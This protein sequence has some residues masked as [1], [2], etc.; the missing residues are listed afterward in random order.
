M[1]TMQA[2][3][4]EKQMH[5]L[6]TPVMATQPMSLFHNTQPPVLGYYANQ[7]P[8]PQV[9]TMPQQP[10]Q[11]IISIPQQTH[12]YF[13]GQQPSAEPYP[14]Q[15]PIPVMERPKTVTRL[16]QLDE[17]PEY[18]DCPYC[19]KRTLTKVAHESSDTTK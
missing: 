14:T 1:S 17:I 9:Q 12:E 7:P 15:R 10:M 4:D 19:N 2:T 13:T 16:S 5:L 3:T 18:I 6:E 11:Q 8:I